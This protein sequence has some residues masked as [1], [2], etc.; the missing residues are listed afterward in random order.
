MDRKPADTVLAGPKMIRSDSCQ[1]RPPAGSRPV[2]K[3]QHAAVAPCARFKKKLTMKGFGGKG[4]MGNLDPETGRS[5]NKWDCTNSQLTLPSRANFVRVAR[6][7][8]RGHVLIAV[9]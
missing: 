8:S 3:Q 6:P 4:W 1:A 7:K 9:D 5:K 2:L